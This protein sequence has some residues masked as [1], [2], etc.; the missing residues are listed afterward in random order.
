MY[1]ILIVICGIIIGLILIYFKQYFINN[2]SFQANQRIS[3]K[4]RK[5][6]KLQQS[7]YQKSFP[8]QHQQNRIYNEEQM[9]NWQH[10]QKVENQIT[11]Q[12]N[13][14]NYSFQSDRQLAKMNTSQEEQELLMDDIRIKKKE[15]FDQ[16][17]PLKRSED[18]LQQ[19]Y[20]QITLNQPKNY[21]DPLKKQRV[22]YSNQV[23]NN[24]HY[25]VS[26]NV[27]VK[28][29]I[30]NLYNMSCLNSDDTKFIGSA[31]ISKNYNDLYI[32]DLTQKQ[33]NLYLKGYRQ[34]SGD[35]NCYFTAIAFQYFE[36]LLNKFNYLEFREFINQIETMEFLIEFN[37]YFIEA[38]LQNQFAKRMTEL[39]QILR[40]NPS[41]LE[42]M[43]ADPNQEFYGLAIICF[44][45]LAYLLYLRQNSQIIVEYKPDLSNELLTWQFQCNDSEMINSSLAKY[46]NI[47][48]NVY[49][50]DQKNSEVTQLKYGQQSKNEIHLIYRPGHYDIGIPI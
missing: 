37:G 41:Q 35:G 9:Q 23:E 28:Q 20:A 27:I 19:K 8:T 16:N 33:L 5:E 18:R 15:N 12:E 47:I 50:I 26:K 2:E 22:V 4:T 3:N 46:L 39:L 7:S 10:P 40:D 32:D 30:F 25:S 14:V 45:N 6:I 43:M 29:K 1:D 17:S 44:R 21:Q 11:K 24:N 34:V 42:Q 13:Q 48:I 49:L 31:I 36:I 38:T